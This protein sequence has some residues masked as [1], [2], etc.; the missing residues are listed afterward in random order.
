MDLEIIQYWMDRSEQT[1]HPT[2]RARYADLAWEVSRLWNKDHPSEASIS[3]PRVLA[4]R[5]IGAYLDAVEKNLAFDSH[6][7]WRF[8]GRAMELALHIRDNDLVER[9]KGL[10]FSYQREQMKSGD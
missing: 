7:T 3:R 4:Q 2:L 5:A 10:A 6:Q 8:L 9:A 1:P